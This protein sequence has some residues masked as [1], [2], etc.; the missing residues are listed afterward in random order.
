[1]EPKIP[2]NR[3]CFQGKELVY[4][5]NAIQNGHISGDGPFTGKCEKL[6][7]DVLG[8]ERALLT[9]SCTHALE[10]AAILLNLQPGDEVILPAFTFVSTV[11][12]FVL[13][14]AKPVFADVRLDTLNLDETKLPELITEKTRAV[15]PVHYGGVA[16]NMNDV[17]AIC[18]PRGIAV[19]EDN[20]HGL[21]GK[22]QG[23]FLGSLGDMA[24]LSFHE[25]KNITCGEGGALLLN[26]NQ[27]RE[28]AEIIRQ[29]GTDRNRFL[30]G[31]VDKY[32]W[33]DVGSSYVP[34]D[35]LAAFL[36]A[37]LEAREHIQEHR[38][39]LWQFYKQHLESWAAE[40]QATLPYAPAD[41]ESAWHLFYILMP[42]EARR[43]ALI[44]HLKARNILSVFHYHPLHLSQ[45]GQRFGGKPGDCPVTEN[46]AGRLLRLPFYNDISEHE[47]LRV[48]EGL[49]S[50]GG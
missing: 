26:D 19:I 7:E 5:A 37:Q 11:N 41:C 49:R 29:K 8:C 31:E 21:F 28:R 47:K 15:V 17:L 14:G 24:T 13:H 18:R 33:V 4:I 32:T 46:V 36:F 20:A 38:R 39:S 27:W 9:P 43:N 34:S 3:A 10:M 6:L 30:R 1:M 48:V 16:C 42:D 45:M 2:F 25:T 50:F 44:D 40:Q 22:Y 23:R 12:A 35:L